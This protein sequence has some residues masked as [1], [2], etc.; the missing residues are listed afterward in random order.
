[1]SVSIR[2]A[3][4]M[5]VPRGPIIEEWATFN[6]YP[7]SADSITTDQSTFVTL[8]ALGI[9]SQTN[10][11]S[12]GLYRFSLTTMAQESFSSNTNGRRYSGMAYPGVAGNIAVVDNRYRRIYIMTAA[13]SNRYTHSFTGVPQNPSGVSITSSYIFLTGQSDRTVR[14]FNAPANWENN[15]AISD[16]GAI[17]FESDQIPDQTVNVGIAATNKRVYVLENPSDYHS[18]G[19]GVSVFDVDGA[20]KR[21]ESF[22]YGD[23]EISSPYGLAIFGRDLLIGSY[24]RILVARQVVRGTTGF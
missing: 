19:L 23:I 21:S 9:N 17:N 11:Y 6:N 8:G 13:G 18:K 15:V 4:M 7:R 3:A 1:M 16:T 10:T 5:M 20:P 24:G 2:S 22:R 14:R 12:N